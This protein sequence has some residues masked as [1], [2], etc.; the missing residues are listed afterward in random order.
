M[1]TVLLI[2]KKDSSFDN[3]FLKS[4]NSYVYMSLKGVRLKK[5][6][7]SDLFIYDTDEI[8]F[9]IELKYDMI[10]FKNNDFEEFNIRK[11]LNEQSLIMLA[12]DNEKA[13]NMLDIYNL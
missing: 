9:D 8:F 12:G 2:G 13:R 1:T 10:I 7:T 6:Q 5:L 4:L 11:V 3:F